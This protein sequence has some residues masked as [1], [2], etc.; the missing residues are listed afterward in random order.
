MCSAMAARCHGRGCPICHSDHEIW[1]ELVTISCKH[2]FRCGCLNDWCD[3][4]HERSAAL[5]CPSCRRPVGMAVITVC[6]AGTDIE[7]FE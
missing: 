6:G 3:D 2:T 4:C 5:V 7:E 1:D